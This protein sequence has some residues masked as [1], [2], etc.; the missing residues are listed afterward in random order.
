MGAGASA[1]ATP[2]ASWA[3][4]SK[5]VLGLDAM[6][7]KY[8]VRMTEATLLGEGQFGRCYRCTLREDAA[9]R[10]AVKVVPMGHMKPHQV[11]NLRR[12]ILILSAIKDHPSVLH[13][14][15]YYEDAVEETAYIVTDVLEGGELFD[16]IL[17]KV[18]YSENDARKCVC[19]MLEVAAWLHAR[20]V[21]HRD[22]KPENLILATSADDT[23]I[24][25]V[26]F[27]LAA[28]VD[29]R[30]AMHSQCGTPQFLAPEIIDAAPPFGPKTDVWA[31]GVI[32]YNLLHGLPPFDPYNEQPQAALFDD[33][34]KGN[35][36][37]APQTFDKVSAEAKDLIAKL[38]E[39][40]PAKRLSAEQALLHPWFLLG[41]HALL[42]KHLD[43]TYSNMK[44]WNARRKLK[45]VAHTVRTS[46]RMAT[47]HPGTG[48]APPNHTPLV[49]GGGVTPY[50]TPANSPPNVVR[51]LDI[52]MAAEAPAPAATH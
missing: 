16:R 5:K 45:Q 4:H 28:H 23:S 17:D 7:E 26:D 46:I 29:D 52:A 12:E 21:C 48:P 36:A 6:M 40:D 15:D 34:R 27:G 50:A 43:E 51:R 49:G 37:F 25:V 20:G 39:R 9:R 10:F 47:K 19:I 18:H 44:K 32:A 38:L 3:E 22:F 11:V 14:H 8:D 35:W 24:H 30:D 1:A 13:L 33:I 31:I 41:D 42:Q 2:E